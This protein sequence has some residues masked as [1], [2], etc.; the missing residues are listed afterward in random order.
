MMKLLTLHIEALTR[1]IDATERKIAQASAS[2]KSLKSPDSCAE[3]AGRAS[4][5]ERRRGDALRG[6][7]RRRKEEGEKLTENGA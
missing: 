4:L 1:S 3:M 6:G 5:P 2:R 7:R